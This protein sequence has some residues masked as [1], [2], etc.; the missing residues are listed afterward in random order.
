MKQL[1]SVCYDFNQFY[2]IMR[3]KYERKHHVREA[4]DILCAVNQS[5]ASVSRQEVEVSL[6]LTDRTLKSYTAD[7]PHL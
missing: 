6:Q 1:S 5:F 7:P 3:R 4:S 2:S